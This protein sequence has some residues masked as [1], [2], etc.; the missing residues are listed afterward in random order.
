[1][2]CITETMIRSILILKILSVYRVRC[3]GVIL[4]TMIERSSLRTWRSFD[5]LLLRGIKVLRDASGIESMLRRAYSSQGIAGFP[6]REKS[7][8]FGAGQQLRSR[9]LGASSVQTGVRSNVQGCCEENIPSSTPI[10][11]PVY[12][13]TVEGACG[14]FAN[15]VL[16]HNCDSAS[17]A[18][19]YMREVGI[20]VRRDE[21]DDDLREQRRY[22]KRL[23]PV[24]DV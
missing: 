17:Q 15:G 13:L 7:L 19:I 14:Y 18:L 20:A 5:R 3:I 22:R 11:H 21:Y 9:T 4:R 23:A 2:R 24:Y 12:N 1:M 8:V 6:L 16:V 10:M